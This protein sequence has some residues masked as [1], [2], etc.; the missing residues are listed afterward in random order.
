[1]SFY[2][3]SET[4]IN[5]QKLYMKYF[6]RLADPGG[7]NYWSGWLSNNNNDYKE[8]ESIFQSEFEKSKII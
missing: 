2:N 3:K 4:T 5:I 1:M 6:N 7:L 8:L